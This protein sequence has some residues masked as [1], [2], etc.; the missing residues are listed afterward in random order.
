MSERVPQA[1]V[2]GLHFEGSSSELTEIIELLDR[3]KIESYA[4]SQK[5][6][7]S[8][9]PPAAPHMGGAWERLIRSV[10]EVM[11]GMMVSTVLTDPQLATLITEV[12]SILNSR[13]LTPVSD[14]INDLDV[15]TP[16]HILLG[17]HRN[18]DYMGEITEYDV[19]SRRRWKQVQA[20]STVFWYRWRREYLPNLTKRS[21]W[22]V[23]TPNYKVG[24][25]VLLCDDDCRRGKW[26]LARITRVMPGEDGIVRVVEIRT[27]DGTYTRPVV[28]LRRLEDSEVPQ[29]EGHIETITK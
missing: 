27:R 5:I 13:P 7:W 3:D 21:R 2:F 20:L 15:L 1:Y 25:L 17:R 10:K 19:L 18:W 6:V 12:E 24:E 23:P 16:N 29:G 22:N 4:T 8:F 26:P 9:N 14:D 11:T 28:K